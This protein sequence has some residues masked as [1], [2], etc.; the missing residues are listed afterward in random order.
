M[1]L[2]FEISSTGD[3]PSIL[4]EYLPHGT[5]TVPVQFGSIDVE[6]TYDDHAAGEQ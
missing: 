3:W 2:S 5:C 1:E 6:T 4:V